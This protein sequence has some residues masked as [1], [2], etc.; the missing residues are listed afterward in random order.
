[1]QHRILLFLVFIVS[2]QFGYCQNRK[3]KTQPLNAKFEHCL[4]HQAKYNR[5]TYK[6]TDGRWKT[7]DRYLNGSIR[8]EK[9]YLNRGLT[10]KTDTART[11]YLNGKIESEKV[12]F[13][14]TRN[15]SWK[16]FYL[17]GQPI[18]TGR[19][20]DNKALPP[21]EWYGNNTY[22]YNP[23]DTID[24]ESIWPYRNF[25]EPLFGKS[26]FSKTSFVD[27]PIHDAIEKNFGFNFVCF[28][29]NAQGIAHDLQFAIHGSEG[30]DE[31]TIHYFS[32][33]PTFIPADSMGIPIES[34][35]CWP[36]TYRQ[37][38]QQ[39]VI[40]DQEIMSYQELSHRLFKFSLERIGIHDFLMAK[41]A[42]EWALYYYDQ[43]P[44]YYVNLAV[45]NEKFGFRHEACAYFE[46]AQMLKPGII[47]EEIKSACGI[48]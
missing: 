20:F 8:A 16:W 4:P 27:F 46:I 13:N 23:E 41:S 25:P 43:D 15:G 9:Y 42:L 17:S 36:G 14:G 2:A 31:T 1:M 5:E 33:F 32:K 39:D 34:C 30:M 18:V 22:I 7:V 48:D 24:L 37:R 28:R 44:G 38:P 6:L 21:W 26:S 29:V 47:S 40:H 10:E 45:C 12:Y 35:H 19:Y 3:G 11:F